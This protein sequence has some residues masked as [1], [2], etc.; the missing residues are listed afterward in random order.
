[1][2]SV[3]LLLSLS[4]TDVELFTG[5]EL[6]S[7]DCTLV[8]LNGTMIGVTRDPEHFVREFRA[9]RRA[10]MP[11]SPLSFSS[12]MCWVEDN[13]DIKFLRDKSVVVNV[14]WR[15]EELATR[16]MFKWIGKRNQVPKCTVRC[17][18]QAS[19]L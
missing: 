15:R 5:T 14:K 6:Y 10:G 18:R 2:I 12:C 16:G 11:H 17:I 1:M 8:L 13:R 9:L 3:F 19:Y 4:L 7:Q